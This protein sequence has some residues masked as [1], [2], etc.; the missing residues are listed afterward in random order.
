MVGAFLWIKV[1]RISDARVAGFRCNGW[2]DPSSLCL[3]CRQG[4]LQLLLGWA[5]Q[6]TQNHETFQFH[7][8][9][10]PCTSKIIG[11]KGFT[12]GDVINAPSKVSVKNVHINKLED[13]EAK[14]ATWFLAQ[15]AMHKKGRAASSLDAFRDAS[16]GQCSPSALSRC[17]SVKWGM[18]SSRPS[19]CER[20]SASWVAPTCFAMMFLSSS[21]SNILG[22]A[23]TSKVVRKLRLS[24]FVTPP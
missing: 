9:D 22:V 14:V 1:V 15:Q 4:Q 19:S 2:N 10:D 11:L 16:E 17:S 18:V 3:P 21:S 8:V 23:Y 7:V 6:Q 24:K 12:Q 20:I 5:F 13:S